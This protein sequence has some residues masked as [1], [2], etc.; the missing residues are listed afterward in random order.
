SDPR[1][2]RGSTSYAFSIGDMAREIH[3]P[4]ITR[5]AFACRRVV[6]FD[7]I[8]DG[9]S[10]TI[11]M[12]EMR[13]ESF[14]TNQSASVLENPSLCKDDATD[15][16]PLRGSRWADGAAGYSLVNT[17][18]PPGSPSCAVGGAEEVDGIYSA[19]SDHPG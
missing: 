2:D 13:M 16:D 6:R 3:E 15:N 9:T 5:G 10:Q 1:A 14:A 11:A 12:A 19:G 8:T 17:I 4:S 7:D 18:L